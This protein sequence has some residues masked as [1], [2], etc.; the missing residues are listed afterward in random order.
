LI[1]GRFRPS[2]EGRHLIVASGD[3]EGVDD[4]AA[5]FVELLTRR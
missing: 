5:L 1:P 3:E 2:P 4:A